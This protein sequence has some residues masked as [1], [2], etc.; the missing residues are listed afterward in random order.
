M[1]WRFIANLLVFHGW[2]YVYPHSRNGIVDEFGKQRM[3]LLRSRCT[4][5]TEDEISQQW[6]N[7]LKS[8]CIFWIVDELSGKWM[9]MAVS[10]EA[11]EKNSMSDG[12]PNGVAR[13]RSPTEWWRWPSIPNGWVGQTDSW[14]GVQRRFDGRPMEA[15][16]CPMESGSGP[17]EGAMGAW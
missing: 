2:F 1:L 4:F 13:R 8:G 16:R 15:N 3:N 7:F 10:S 5:W 6:I 14:T 12:G 11:D 9:K 17:T